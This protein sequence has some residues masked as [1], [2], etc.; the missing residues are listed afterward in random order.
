MP[1][2]LWMLL[3]TLKHVVIRSSLLT[4]MHLWEQTPLQLSNLLPTTEHLHMRLFT[5]VCCQ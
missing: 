2:S 5:T 1:Q 4:Q 3:T